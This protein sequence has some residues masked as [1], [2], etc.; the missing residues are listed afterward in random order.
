MKSNWLGKTGIKVNP[1]GFGG[2]PIQRIS[3]DE[4]IELVS[5]A[6]ELGIN[7]FDT[8]R[9]YTDSERK[10]GM[11]IKGSR[12][13]VVIATKS[14]A[15]KYNEMKKDIQTSLEQLGVNYID[16]YQIHNLRSE[17]DFHILMSSDGGYRALQEAKKSGLIRH[18]GITGHDVDLL[19]ET[20]KTGKFSTVQVP[21][22]AL[23]NQAKSELFA[24]ARDREIG[25]IVMKPLAGGAIRSTDL[26]LRYILAHDVSVVI[27]GMESIEQLE[28]NLR[29]ASFPPLSDREKE[30]LLSEVKAIGKNFC[31]RCGYCLPCPEGIDIPTIFIFEGYYTRYN[32]P[33]W[34]R[35]R[36]AG[37]KVKAD[38]CQECGLCEEKCPYQL[39]IREMLKKA[40]RVLSDDND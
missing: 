34:S 25:I 30:E 18:I 17:K 4:A 22:N 12:N 29:A 13:K 16:L 39:P 2:I 15:L 10:I 35:E 1:L 28:E 8:A 36:Y 21:F 19:V 32:M 40:H 26:A 20:L 23:E 3:E 14:P 31:R 7:F 38:S 6:V 9:G 24:I 11:G 27:P 37:L 33:R 5:K